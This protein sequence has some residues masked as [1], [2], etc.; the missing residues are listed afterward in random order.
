MQGSHI[1]K[2]KTIE[3]IT[4][5]STSFGL[6]PGSFSSSCQSRASR[7]TRETDVIGENDKI[8]VEGRGS[9]GMDVYGL[10]PWSQ[11]VALP[12]T[13]LGVKEERER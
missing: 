5:R 3:K 8:E 1:L 13:D 10:V 7:S 9:G 6:M 11:G 2:M 4:Q 12:T